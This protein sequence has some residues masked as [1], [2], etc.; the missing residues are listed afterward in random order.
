MKGV[1]DHVMPKLNNAAWFSLIPAFFL[2]IL[3]AASLRAQTPTTTVV[4]GNAP[5][6]VA[7]NP[8]TNK[9][10]VVN[11]L[12]NNVTVID[13]ATNNTTTV[14]AGTQPF[15]VAVNPLTNKIYVPNP[16]SDSV[17]VIDGATNTTTTVVVG[18]SPRGVAV[19]PVTN[20]IYVPNFTS[21]TVTVIDG[22]TNSTATVAVGTGPFSVAVNPL[23]NK[24]YVTNFTSN[25]VTVID[26]ASNS[27][28]TVAAGN[29][30]IA[31][32]VNPVTNKIYVAN[33]DSNN[34]TVI[35][36]G[37]NTTATVAAGTGPRRVAVNP[38][39]NKIYVA[40]LNSDNVTVI[41]GATNSTTTVATGIFPSGVA[42]NPVTNKIYV[43]NAGSNNVTVIDEATNTTTTVAA[44]SAPRAVAVN[45]VTNKIYVAN[46]GNVTVIDGATNTTTTV[47]VGTGPSGPVAVNPVTNKFYVGNQNGDNVT[48]ITEQQVQAIPLQANITPLADNQTGSLTPSFSFTATSTFSPFAPPPQGL[49]FQVDTWQGAWLAATD[50]GSGTFSGQTQALQPGFH[51]LYAYS[52]DGQEATSTITGFQSSPL[53][54]NI[55]AYGFL[56]SLPSV[57]LSAASL[58][59][60]GQTVNT[61][62]VEQTV[63]LSNPGGPLTITSITITGPDSG[64]F[65]L[66]ATTTCPSTGTVGAGADCTIDVTFTPTATGAATGSLNVTDDAPG[67]P[68]VVS[69]TGE[70]LGPI[71]TLGSTSLN[72]TDQLLGTTSTGQTVT[73]NNTGSA[74][75]TITGITVS[76][77]FAQTNDCGVSLALG[78]G[79]SIDVTF[80]PTV[81]GLL[82]GDLTIASDDPSGPQMVDL[83]G[84][85]VAPAVG[86]TS[87]SL[88]FV[89]QLVGTTGDSQIVTLTNTGSASL[90]FSSIVASGD[91]AQTN[92][93]GTS[94][95]AAASCT[96]TVSFTPTG[97]GIRNGEVILSSNDPNSPQSILLTGEGIG[98][99]SSLTLSASSL[100]FADQLCTTTSSAQNVTL[101]NTGNA[102]INISSIF[103]SGEFT[104]TN[105]CGAS[106]AAAASCTITVSFTPKV[107]GAR[108]GSVTI[109]TDAPGSPHGIELSG[110][111]V[112]LSLMV[113]A[114]SQLEKTIEAGET[115]TFQMT[116]VADGV[117][118]MCFLSCSGAPAGATCTVEPA[119]MGLGG[120][121][122]TTVVASVRTTARTSG[123]ATFPGPTGRNP[124]QPWFFVFV[125]VVSMV[126]AMRRRGSIIPTLR[127]KRAYVGLGAILLMVGLWTAC[128]TG[129]MENAG[130]GTGGTPPGTSTLTV[131][132][133]TSSGQSMSAAVTLNVR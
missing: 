89:A 74:A 25:D 114:A 32:A 30:P 35:D 66:A 90:N 38:V 36:G 109:V 100:T 55:T 28:T 18:D 92:D 63:T 40:N 49:F 37:S 130:G 14:V 124:W 71:V 125:V 46:G 42:V 116:L 53:T 129:G 29:G 60:G 79:C 44:G 103:A 122:T 118:E 43:A 1:A 120:P 59:F 27:T 19:N 99:V 6:G 51:I 86:L 131:T 33:A 61:T 70:G 115:A 20:K 133:R 97:D 127:L 77:D 24:I 62:S 81:T 76:G 9:I 78:T 84:T 47:A 56:V 121:V 15:N 101:T 85:G 12:S 13:G 50:Q 126:E 7:V 39:T 11:Q 41:D 113:T 107:I 119:E 34:V 10:Y 48:V 17:T 8:V 128:G 96:I 95:A 68:Q 45:P 72:F 82:S 73:L 110:T 98:V 23:T 69:L 26:G 75:L 67:S 91:F 5:I 4:A 112:E 65:A 83:F 102:V 64:D 52:T 3:P 88:T 87:T 31:V 21:N 58:D 108:T 123:A 106:V 105:D 80:T 93:C 117:T 54:S 57:A 104:V 94:V 111:A 2:L 22:A 16:S 132:V